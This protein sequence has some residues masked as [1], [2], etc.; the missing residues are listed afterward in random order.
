MLQINT[1]HIIFQLHYNLS[2]SI[3]AQANVIENTTPVLYEM[4]INNDETQEAI[5]T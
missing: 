2:P 5:N 3:I 4:Y 1:G